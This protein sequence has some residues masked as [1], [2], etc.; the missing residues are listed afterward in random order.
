MPGAI[1]KIY[2]LTPMLG[3]GRRYTAATLRRGA[4]AAGE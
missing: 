1:P 4:V 2:G 3:V